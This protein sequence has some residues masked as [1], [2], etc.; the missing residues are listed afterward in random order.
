MQ[1]LG[2]LVTMANL[3]L[4]AVIGV[5]LFRLARRQGGGVE[6][7]LA[8]YF[9]FYVFLSGTLSCGLYVGWADPE[10]AVPSSVEV[11]LNLTYQLLASIGVTGAYLFTWHTF[12]PGSDAAKGFVAVMLSVMAASLVGIGLSEGFAIRVVPGPAYWV[13]YVTKIAFLPWIAVESFRHGGLQ[14]RR[15]SLGLA[16]P[17]V[18]NRFWL[19]GW[20]ATAMLLMGLSDPLARILYVSRAGTTTRFL[21]EVGTSIVNTTVVYSSAAGVVAATML[22]LT[23][24]PTA[25]YRRWVES[26]AAH[27][28]GQDG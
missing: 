18:A 9:F 1:L 21:P 6:L 25:R 28:I 8:T 12:R 26:R 5:R 16:D 2:G 11:P 15:M 10:M 24:F 3:L 14:R 22:F 20:W 27:V 19:W 4:A 13:H 7:G 23:F 17:L